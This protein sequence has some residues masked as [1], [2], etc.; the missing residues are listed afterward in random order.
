MK[1]CACC[2]CGQPAASLVQLRETDVKQE[3]E[4]QPAEIHGC[5]TF[6]RGRAGS[7]LKLA[8]TSSTIKGRAQ[9]S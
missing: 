5:R 9:I 2:A 6:E 1:G 7:E 4:E 3:K 8:G